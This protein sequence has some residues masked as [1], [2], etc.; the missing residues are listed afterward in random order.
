MWRKGEHTG[1]TAWVPWRTVLSVPWNPGMPVSSGELLSDC[2]N[3]RPSAK[4]MILL[5]S[6]AEAKI[7]RICSKLR[8]RMRERKST[9]SRWESRGRVREM[10]CRETRERGCYHTEKSH[11]PQKAGSLPTSTLSSP[12]EYIWSYLPATK[13]PPMVSLCSE[14]DDAVNLCVAHST[15]LPHHLHHMASPHQLPSVPSACLPSFLPKV[16]PSPRLPFIKKK[17]IYFVLFIYLAALSLS[18]SM[19]NLVPRPGNEPGPPVSGAW[20]FSYWITREVPHSFFF[21][22]FLI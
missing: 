17:N 8:Q 3:L 22:F 1:P 7:W 12:K 10:N 21:F 14:G 13:N 11:K 6:T 20:S 15:C 9:C 18:C 2:T 19:W 5:S 4:K 16:L